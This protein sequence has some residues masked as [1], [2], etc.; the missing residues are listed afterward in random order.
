MAAV[1]VFKITI[2]ALSIF[3][4]LLAVSLILGEVSVAR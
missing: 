2:V 4:G 3:S 1:L